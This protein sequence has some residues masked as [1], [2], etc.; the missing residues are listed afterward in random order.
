MDPSFR[1]SD[2][3]TRM[4]WESS[5]TFE[6][7]DFYK[8]AI[9]RSYPDYSSYDDKPMYHSIPKTGTTMSRS[10]IDRYH[11]TI[12]MITEIISDQCIN[13]CTF[14][15]QVLSFYGK[16]S[17]PQTK[18]E[19]LKHNVG[20]HANALVYPEREQPEALDDVPQYIYPANPKKHQE[21]RQNCK[22]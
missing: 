13:H 15:F 19:V 20:S 3:E 17:F 5:A 12:V 9:T 16:C 8:K 18:S 1:L 11:V 21:I 2:T 10:F 22:I 6:E 14:C 7:P 4:K